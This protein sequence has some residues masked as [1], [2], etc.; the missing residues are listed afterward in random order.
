[1]VSL[2]DIQ[3]YIGMKIP[4]E[5]GDPGMLP[6]HIERPPRRQRPPKGGPRPGGGQGRG[7]SGSGDGKPAEGTATGKPR[8]RRRRNK[9]PGQPGTD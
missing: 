4:V 9:K 7:R 6:D 5:A 8:R 2:P 3:E 1:V